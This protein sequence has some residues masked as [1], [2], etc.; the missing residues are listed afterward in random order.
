MQR[1]LLPAPRGLRGFLHAARGHPAFIAL[2]STRSGRT[3]G[4][5]A[6][7]ALS[8]PSSSTDTRR[9][10][11]WRGRAAP[12]P[13]QP[14]CCAPETCRAGTMSSSVRTSHRGHDRSQRLEHEAAVAPGTQG[15]RRARNPPSRQAWWPFPS[16]DWRGSL[17]PA[18]NARHSSR[19]FST[20]LAH[21]HR[22]RRPWGAA[23]P[24]VVPPVARR[25][26]P[27][28]GGGERR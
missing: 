5:I 26:G 23:P 4:A 19:A 10:K 24:L 6:T 13:P 2:G 12:R 1:R 3:A 22:R 16:R 21:L 27:R 15:T 18:A 25:T 14:S 28:D 20:L 9:R 11:V 8:S 17:P 7:A